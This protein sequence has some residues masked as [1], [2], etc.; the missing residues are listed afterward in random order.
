MKEVVRGKPR[1]NVGAVLFSVSAAV[2]VIGF[3]ALLK[4]RVPPSEKL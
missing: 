2:P 4:Y 3:A 1:G